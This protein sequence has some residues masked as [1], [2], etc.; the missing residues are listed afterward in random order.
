VS[1]SKRAEDK[2]VKAFV[3]AAMAE[4]KLDAEPAYIERSLRGMKIIGKE[5]TKK[6]GKTVR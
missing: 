1:K 6:T 3:G 2:R 5:S 4:M